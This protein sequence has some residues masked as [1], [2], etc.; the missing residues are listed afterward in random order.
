MLE[1]LISLPCLSLAQV[2]EAAIRSSFARHNGN[3]RR[4]MREL[5]L[6]RMTLL[7]RLSK[8]GLRTSGKPRPRYLQEADILRAFQ[9]H[10]HEIAAELKISDSTLIRWINKCA[11]FAVEE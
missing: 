9:R 2:E 6:S 10:R 3:R 8:L 5:G 1:D 4:M 7:R 11:P